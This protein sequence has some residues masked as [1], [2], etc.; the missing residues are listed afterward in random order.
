MPD[1]IQ[2]LIFKAVNR[3]DSMYH[4]YFIIGEVELVPYDIPVKIFFSKMSQIVRFCTLRT[5]KKH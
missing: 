1:T 2:A 3:K 5:L 4:N